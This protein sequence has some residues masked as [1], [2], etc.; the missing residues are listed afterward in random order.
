MRR[1]RKKLIEKA[2]RAID[3]LER[4]AVELHLQIEFAN[5]ISGVAVQ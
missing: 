4:R 2:C 3:Y 5:F 1:Q